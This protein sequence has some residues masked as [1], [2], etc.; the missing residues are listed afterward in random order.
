MHTYI[1]IHTCMHTYAH[2]HTYI[3]T[4][5]RIHAY[6]HTYLLHLVALCSGV[7]PC[8][9]AS[10]EHVRIKFRQ[11]T[12]LIVSQLAQPTLVLAL[13][14]A[15]RETSALQ[16]STPSLFPI[17]KAKCSGLRRPSHCH[18]MCERVCKKPMRQSYALIVSQ[19]A[20]P[21]VVVA[22]GSALRETSAL[23]QAAFPWTAARCS[24]VPLVG[25]RACM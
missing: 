7:K 3:H 10:C 20:Q 19:P 14:S 11:N 22:L 2:M 13:T 9:H 21:T 25:C 23:M 24:A 6:I 17:P 18:A 8:C 12:A 1:R 16:A 4:Y 15:P 5:I